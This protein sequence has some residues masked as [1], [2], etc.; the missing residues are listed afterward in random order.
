[1]KFRWK[2]RLPHRHPA[3][4]PEEGVEARRAAQEASYAHLAADRELAQL[5][6]QRPRVERLHSRISRELEINHFGEA[7]FTSWER[8]RG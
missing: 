5:A 3:P 1:M 7:L 8:R 6:A 4:S 2:V